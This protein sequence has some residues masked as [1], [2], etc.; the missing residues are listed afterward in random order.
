MIDSHCHLNSPEYQHDYDA[1]IRHSFASGVEKIIVPATTPSDFDLTLSLA[2]SYDNIYAAIG[3]HP[4]DARLFNQS[5][6]ERIKT[7]ASNPKVVAIGEIGLDFH[8]SFSPYEEQK[9]ALISQIRLARELDLP[10]ILHNRASDDLMLETLHNELLPLSGG[11]V[12]C[13]SSNLFFLENILKLNLH[14]SFTAN[15][16]F[17]NVN[18]DDVILATPLERI[19]LETD[20]PFMTP[21]PNRS[22]RNV[23][24][25]VKFVAEKIANIKKISI[26]EVIEMTTKNAKNLF[27]LSTFL[28]LFFLGMNLYSQTNEEEYY[29]EDE[30]YLDEYPE[31]YDPYHRVLGIAPIIG[32][33]TFVEQYTVGI[34]NVSADGIFTLGG[35]LSYRF[36]TAFIAQASYTYAKNMKNIDALPDIEKHLLDPDIHQTVELSVLAMLIP[37]HKVNFYGILGATYFMNQRSANPDGLSKHYI[38]D[39]KV[40]LNTG[41]GFFLNFDLKSAGTLT[42]NGE[43][44]VGFRFDKLSL[45]YDPRKHYTDPHYHVPTEVGY[46]SSVTRASL[47]WYLP[48]FK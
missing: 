43:W 28:I 29:Y 44:K 40:G 8:Y 21:P 9:T 26:N 18:L 16:T 36:A 11:V 31:N 10:I 33:N 5:V 4:H 19:L 48:F 39:N 35:S 13:F 17:K 7:L 15:I 42:F 12:H 2:E 32:T 37:R 1:V 20:G 3:V 38:I 14:V 47:I 27:K 23:P 30:E 25:N 24:E 34:R 41:I 22:K 46:F 6:L 45:S